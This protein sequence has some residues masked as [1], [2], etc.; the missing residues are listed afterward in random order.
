MSS[1]GM[2]LKE[3]RKEKGWSQDVLGEHVGIHGRHI[4][5]YEIGKAMPNAD[6][7]IKIAKAFDVSIDY[8]LLDDDTVPHHEKIRDKSLLKKFQAVEQM[9]GKDK[10]VVETLIEAFIKKQ[11][12]E[13]VLQE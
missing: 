3:L 9:D 2:K 8:L 7:V 11:Q 13:A 5:K 4:G 6:T 1:F 12:I 10:A